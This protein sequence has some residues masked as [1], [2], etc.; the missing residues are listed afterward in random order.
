MEQRGLVSR[1]THTGSQLI[2]IIKTEKMQH[3]T[4]WDING[5]VP[6]V[7]GG[8]KGNRSKKRT[9]TSVLER[10]LKRPGAPGKG[11]LAA[12]N[13]Q[14]GKDNRGENNKQEES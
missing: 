9:T 3:R 10:W 2:M 12:D 4:L 7:R 13:R 1:M 11:T 14:V 5:E 8:A 6:E